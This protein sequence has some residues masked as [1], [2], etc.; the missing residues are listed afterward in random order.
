MVC[1][2]NLVGN[3]ASVGITLEHTWTLL[4]CNSARHQVGEW[5][6]KQVG[7]NSIPSE[8]EITAIGIMTPG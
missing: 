7:V 5:M 1:L 6:L 8:G 4:H 2:N 3:M